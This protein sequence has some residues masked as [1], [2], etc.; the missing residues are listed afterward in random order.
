M[1]S[2]SNRQSVFKNIP[3]DDTRFHFSICKEFETIK[4]RALKV[5]EDSEEMMEMI[6]YI[7]KARIGGIKVLSDRIG[8]SVRRMNY[9]LDVY[10]F[11]EDHIGLNCTTLLWPSE[12]KPVFDQNEEV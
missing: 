5:P 9:L 2:G 4:E 11:S 3:C 6:A 1:Q 7:E 10:F 12:I 8:E